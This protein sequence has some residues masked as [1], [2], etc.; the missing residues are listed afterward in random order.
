MNVHNQEVMPL[1]L[2]SSGR[3]M[4]LMSGFFIL[5]IFRLVSKLRN[6]R[7]LKGQNTR[8]NLAC[9]TACMYHQLS[10]PKVVVCNTACILCFPTQRN[11]RSKLS[12]MDPYAAKYCTQRSTIFTTYDIFAQ[13]PTIGSVKI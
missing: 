13:S 8:C 9:N 11:I 2:H 5:S 3:N 12:V 6:T 1:V 4:S 7:C 10:T